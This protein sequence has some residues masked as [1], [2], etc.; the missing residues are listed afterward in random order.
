MDDLVQYDSVVLPTSPRFRI[1]TRFRANL[2]ELTGKGF[3]ALNEDE[4]WWKDHYDI[5]LAHGYKL[6]PR[7]HPDWKPSWSGTNVNPGACE[8]SLEHGVR[9]HLH[10]VNYS[11]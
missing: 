11:H 7:Y 2:E 4:I 1:S 9:L 5:I 10:I 8:D 6:R 3:F